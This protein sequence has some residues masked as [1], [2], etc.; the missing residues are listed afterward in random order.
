MLF[1]VGYR[2]RHPLFRDELPRCVELIDADSLEQL[3]MLFQRP[4]SEGVELIEVKALD[5]EL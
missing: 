2:R 3:V 4:D 5:G 1:E